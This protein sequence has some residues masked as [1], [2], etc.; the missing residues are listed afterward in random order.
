MEVEAQEKGKQVSIGMKT[1]KKQD[2]EH[3]N[4]DHEE[5]LLGAAVEFMEVDGLAV[6]ENVMYPSSAHYSGINRNDV[7]NVSLLF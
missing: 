1:R 3:A 4:R 7:V 2:R 6:V 5:G